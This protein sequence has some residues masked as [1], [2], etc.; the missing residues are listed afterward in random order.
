MLFFPQKAYDR[1]LEVITL[2]TA[3]SLENAMS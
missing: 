1:Y 3:F 2:K